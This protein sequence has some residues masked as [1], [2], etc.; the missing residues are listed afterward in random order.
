M[1]P[2]SL[3]PGPNVEFARPSGAWLPMQVKDSCGNVRWLGLW[4]ASTVTFAYVGIDRQ[5]GDMDTTRPHLPRQHLSKRALAKLSHGQVQMVFP[6]DHLDEND[7][8]HSA[9][10]V[11]VLYASETPFDA[12]KLRTA[13]VKQTGQE[14]KTQAVSREIFDSLL[15][16]DGSLDDRLARKLNEPDRARLAAKKADWLEYRRR[17][18]LQSSL[19]W[20]RGYFERR[21]GEM[22]EAERLDSLAKVI[23]Q[24]RENR[25]KL[26]AFTGKWAE[27]TR[28]RIELAGANNIPLGKKIILTDQFSPTDNLMMDVFK[29]R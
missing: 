19:E 20:D 14:P 8:P 26:P 17:A 27:Y 3:V 25:D 5:M 11:I 1:L 16:I 10:S 7:P 6:T 24:E 2:E 4:P 18:E 21:K 29:K 28:L 23:L 13:T 9:R 15:A 22:D 12:A